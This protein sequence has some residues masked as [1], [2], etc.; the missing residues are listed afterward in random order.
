MFRIMNFEMNFNLLQKAKTVG[1][2]WFAMFW[3]LL[4][5]PIAIQ[6]VGFIAL[7]AFPMFGILSSSE[8]CESLFNVSISFSDNI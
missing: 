5:Q 4:L 6:P 8:T 3:F 2:I 7:F 1:G